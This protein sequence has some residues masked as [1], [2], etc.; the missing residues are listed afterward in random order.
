MRLTIPDAGHMD[1]Y[2]TKYLRLS[3]DRMLNIIIIIRLEKLIKEVSKQID[4]YVDNVSRTSHLVYITR[5]S[6]ATY[7]RESISYCIS[8]NL[9]NITQFS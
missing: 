8:N 9:S 2:N 4:S 5:D 6:N 1:I 3:V 7:I